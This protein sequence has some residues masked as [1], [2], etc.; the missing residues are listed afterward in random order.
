MVELDRVQ[1]NTGLNWG[2]CRLRDVKQKVMVRGIC[3]KYVVLE[4]V[5]SER[6]GSV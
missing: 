4:T 2:I 6:K 5:R 3:N 1:L